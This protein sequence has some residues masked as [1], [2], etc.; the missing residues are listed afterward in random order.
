MTPEPIPPPAPGDPPW[1]GRPVPLGATWDGEGTNFALWAAAAEAVELCLFDAAGTETRIPLGESTYQVWHGYVP[2]IGPGQRY[3][4]RVHGRYDPG[5]GRRANPSKL[6]LDPYARAIDGDFTPEPPVFGY[7]GDPRGDTRDTRDSA[8]YVP[9]SVVVHDAFPWGS[10]R[11]PDTAWDDTVIYELHVRGFTRRHPGIPE[12]LRGTYAGLAH[13]AAIAHL[14]DL[15]V[16]AVELL[17]VHQFVTEPAVT[18]R[19]LTNYWGYNT[20]G[21]FA[22]HGA[23]ASVPGEQVREFKAMVR[24]LHA[25]GIEVILDVVYNHTAEGD[26]AGPTLCFRGIDNAGYYRLLADEPR[27]YADYTGCGNTLDVRRPYVLQMLMDSL[28]YWVTEMHVDGFRFDLASALARSFHD[29]DKLSAFFDVIHQDPV[30]SRVKLIA[31]PWDVGEGGYQ[32]GEFPP[33]WT[34]WNGKYRDTVRSFWAGERIGVRDLGYRLTGSSDLYADD[35]RRPF[36]SINFVTSH[37]GFTLRDL[38]SYRRKHNEA[39]GEGNRDGDNENRSSNGGHEGEGADDTVVVARRRRARSQ[40][41]TLLLSTGVPMLLAGDELWRTQGGNNNAYC[42]DNEVSWVDWSTLDDPGTADLLA[43]VRRL[44][45]VRRDSPVL[46]QRAFFAGRAVP[47]GDGRK[48]LAWFRPDGTEMTE[49]EWHSPDTR[50]LGMYLDGDGIRQRGPR[51]ERLA[52]ES[53]LLVLHAGAE[54]AAFTLPGPPWATGYHVV[55]DT[56]YG[57]GVP[58]TGADRPAAGL[59]L[60]LA[61]SSAVLLRTVRTSP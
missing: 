8:P 59:D 57:D 44:V 5:H 21:F 33:L 27:R 50:T 36:A 60:P 32:V 9:R 17:P 61:A 12:P 45:A 30:V 29:V 6:L 22:P 38:V 47:G 3:G 56:A 58:P 48:D 15:G 39:N 42:Q 13:P 31:E 54:D 55:V 41:L 24:A 7:D 43:L 11:P 49:R 19:G 53:Y 25:A 46:R 28:R 51:G 1:P 10:D 23:Y 37:D 34:E 14:V 20:I 52:D 16:T 35:G 18:R 4:F 26:E 40:L 2:R